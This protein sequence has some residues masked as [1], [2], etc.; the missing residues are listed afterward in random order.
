MMGQAKL[1]Q[2]ALAA[3]NAY[4][5]VK[6]MRGP[7]HPVAQTEEGDLLILSGPYKGFKIR[8]PKKET[9]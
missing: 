4:I 6:D 8:V 7:M 1:K 3:G 9:I 5:E 2:E